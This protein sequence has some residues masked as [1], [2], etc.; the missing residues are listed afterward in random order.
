[1]STLMEAREVLQKLY[2]KYSFYIEKI[3]RFILG[4]FVF[5]QIN[6][7]V[8]FMESASSGLV[9]FALAVI[10]AFPP[11]IIMVLVASALILAHMY[12]LS[13]S[14]FAVVAVV[15][16]VLY[17]LFLR[18]SPKH[19][20]LTL[21][22]PLALVFNVPL[23]IP[24]A[25][26][27]VGIPGLMVPAICGIIVFYLLNYIQSAVEVTAE[28][29]MQGMI[30]EAV[31]IIQGFL[32]NR[33]MWVMMV[34]MMLI[35]PLVFYLKRISINYAWKLASVIGAL[36]A[37]II[38]VIGN[39]MAGSEISVTMAFVNMI[40]AIGVGLIL[41]FLFF[42][43]NY[44]K[45]ERVQFEDN[46]YYYYVKAVPKIGKALNFQSNVDSNRRKTRNSASASS[47]AGSNS[48][49]R[50][51]ARPG[52]R[53]KPKARQQG[54]VKVQS[55]GTL[56]DRDQATTVIGASQVRKLREMEHR[57]GPNQ[58]ND[59]PRAQAGRKRPSTARP[60]GERG[61]SLEHTNPDDIL[62]T[63]SLTAELGLDSDENSKL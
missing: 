22:V 4:L 40:L 41:E 31:S 45:T 32:G 5:Y 33:D 9:T 59:R 18:F 55:G 46:Q 44:S 42:H 48:K 27:L 62:L 52:E 1:M 53:A 8:G 15:F 39:N 30:A 29:D 57:R 21:I 63:R 51:G 16:I 7:K 3:A 6:S 13:L 43:V 60:H 38:I 37:V 54:E 14:L 19:A 49:V 58:R 25:F 26:G 28:L 50:Q 12:A 34:M 2:S 24:I 23:I 11:T 61:S 56:S 35:I 17:A 20:Y 47:R 10:C 36:T